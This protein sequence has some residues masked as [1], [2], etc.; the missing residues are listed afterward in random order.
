MNKQH[1]FSRRNFLRTV[2]S[3]TIAA[4]VLGVEPMLQ[5]PHSQVAAAPNSQGSNQRANAC[6][7]LRRETAQ[8]GLLNTP[9]NLQHASNLDEE[10]YPNKIASYSKALPHNNDGTVVLSAFAA[11]TKAVKSGDPDDF[12]AIPMGGDFR[13]TNRKQA[14]LSISR[15]RTHMRWC[16][17]RRRR[18]PVE[19]WRR[20]FLRTT[21]W[22]CCGMFLFLNTLQIQSPMPPRRTCHCTVQTSKVL[23]MEGQLLPQHCFVV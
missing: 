4:G 15:A 1:P 16:N 23:R 21:G 20:R 3:T 2:G 8:A 19:N 14:L 17:L 10:L 6:A 13:L 11:L 5:L 7:K 18:L 12:N 9:A 22:P